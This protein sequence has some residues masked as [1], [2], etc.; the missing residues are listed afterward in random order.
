MIAYAS[1]GAFLSL[2]YFDL[3][4]QLMLTLLL[5]EDAIKSESI[6]PVKNIY[7]R[8]EMLGHAR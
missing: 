1:G 4:W 5:I 3:P 2:A 6:E 8:R 7:G